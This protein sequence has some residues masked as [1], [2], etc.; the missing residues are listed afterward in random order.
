MKIELTEEEKK[1]WKDEGTVVGFYAG[2]DH[3]SLDIY[4]DPSSANSL[5]GVFVLQ[6]IFGVLNGI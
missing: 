4:W 6:A 2:S 5:L 1:R 3:A